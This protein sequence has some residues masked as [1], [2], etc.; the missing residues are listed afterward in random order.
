M[1][2]VVNVDPTKMGKHFFTS[3]LTITLKGLGLS[4]YM[5]HDDL[6][7]PFASVKVTIYLVY[8]VHLMFNTRCCEEETNI[9]FRSQSKNMFTKLW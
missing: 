7:E 5:T 1:A 6:Y 2:H 4:I 8:D 3:L 9:H